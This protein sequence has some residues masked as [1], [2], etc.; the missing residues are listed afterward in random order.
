VA[1]IN[2]LANMSQVV[3]IPG[4]TDFNDFTRDYERE[5]IARLEAWQKSDGFLHFR[6][7]DGLAGHWH[8]APRTLQQIMAA[9]HQMVAVQHRI[10]FEKLHFNSIASHAYLVI[11]SRQT[12]DG[13]DIDVIDSN[14]PT[15]TLTVSYH[16]GQTSLYTANGGE[17]MVP[18]LDFEGDMGRINSSLRRYCAAQAHPMP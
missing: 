18:Y 12:A 11:G 7:V 9:I 4:Y 6:W 10:V 8:V 15:D 14:Y 3:V 5:I 17:A 13:Y 16:L 2:A 1:I